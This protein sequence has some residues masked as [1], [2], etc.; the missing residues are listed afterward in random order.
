MD[1]LTNTQLIAGAGVALGAWWLIGQRILAMINPKLAA[2]LAQIL[3][4]L[5][6]E[7]TPTVSSSDRPAPE[8]FTDHVQT[9]M[10]AAPAADHE[11]MCCYLCEGLTE[12]ETLRREVTR[13]SP[14]A[15]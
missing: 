7:T 2:L 5:N 12:A 10:G 14:V 4:I 9:I 3:K 15:E 1:S 11:T 13:L 6:I 8:G